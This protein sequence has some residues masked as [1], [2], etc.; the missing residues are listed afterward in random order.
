[1]ESSAP[2]MSAAQVVLRVLAL[3]QTMTPTRAVVLVTL[4]ATTQT[5]A[6]R[7]PGKTTT[8]HRALHVLVMAS[9][10]PM[11]SAAQVVLRV[12]ALIQ[13]MTPTRA[14]IRMIRTVTTQTP[15]QQGYVKPTT[16]HRALHV[17]VMA[18][19]VPMT[20]AAQMVLRVLAL[21]QTMT[22]TRA[23]IR[24]I[25]TV[26]TQTPVQQGYVKPTTRHRA[27]HVLVMA[28]SVP[29]TS[30]A[31]M[32]LRVLPL[33]QTMPEARAV[34]RMIR[35]VTT[36]TPVQ[37]GYVK[38]TTRHRALHVLVMASSVPMTSAAQLVLPLLALIQ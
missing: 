3:I 17:L 34:F 12:L 8:S 37:Q 13:T 27:L 32:V 20:S 26:T 1:M 19:S 22:P 15:V 6:Q 29:M 25:R 18:S 21:I 16:R 31:Q 11:T 2:M 7:E 28:S 33:T 5:P 10:V 14:V 9:S 38:T 23:V 36:Q 30:A 35:T 4:T 24:M